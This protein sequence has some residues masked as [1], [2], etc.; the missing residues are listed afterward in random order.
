[1]SKTERALVVV[2]RCGAV[3]LLL[4]ALAVFMPFPWMREIHDLFGQGTLADVPI[5]GYLTRSVAA[6]YAYHGALV[7]L[8]SFDVRRY[9]AVIRFLAWANVVFGVVLAV[10]DVWV[11]MPVFWT[12]LE[13]PGVIGFGLVVL[14]LARRIRQSEG[15]QTSAQKPS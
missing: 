4:A 3:V 1:M 13:G 8:L 7:L 15:Q 9:A 6:F 11:G 12:M 2:L 14:L 10:I 5:V